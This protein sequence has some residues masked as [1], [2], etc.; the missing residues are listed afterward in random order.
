[1]KWTKNYNKIPKLLGCAFM[2]NSYKKNFKGCNINMKRK[3]KDFKNEWKY[4]KENL[5]NI[6]IES[7]IQNKQNINFAK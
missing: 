1:M 2:S 3:E 6:K 5:N 7:T 4:S